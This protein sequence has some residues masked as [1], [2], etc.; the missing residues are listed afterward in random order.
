[1]ELNPLQNPNEVLDDLQCNGLVILRRRGHFA[2]GDDA[3]LLAN[4]VRARRDEN[5]LD[6]GT[7]TGILALLVHAKCGTRFTAL[8][9][10]TDFADM[11]LR[12]ISINKLDEQIL[13]LHA[14]AREAHKRL[15][16]ERFDGIVCNP[17]YHS[18]GTKSP[19]LA[20]AAATHEEMLTIEDLAL[21]AKRMLKNGG[22][23]YLCYPSSGIARLFAALVNEGITPKRMRTVVTQAGQAPSLVLIEARK[24]A[25]HGLTWEGEN[26]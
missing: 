25:A 16:Y 3:V 10:Q 2:Y 11:A 4:F 24:G 5:Y 15:G 12:S 9:I 1:M 13:V 19:S 23:L 8:E 7:G 14:D 17:P 26:A 20:R 6:I 22:K 18:G 21:C